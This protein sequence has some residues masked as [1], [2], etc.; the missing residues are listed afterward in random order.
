MFIMLFCIVSCKRRPPDDVTTDVLAQG[1]TD[2]AEKPE[3]KTDAEKTEDELPEKTDDDK[4]DIN[5]EKE[6]NDEKAEQNNQDN[7]QDTS[8]NSETDN[9]V[10]ETEPDTSSADSKPTT[11][12]ESWVTIT[13]EKAPPCQVTVDD[14]FE[15]G[16]VLVLLMR[17]Q[18]AARQ[19]YT[20]ADFPGVDIEEI[21][22]GEYF[23][24]SNNHIS[25]SLTLTQK[26]KGMV[27]E[28]VRILEQ[29]PIVYCATPNV[30]F[31]VIY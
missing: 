7:V 4:T 2:D 31:E 11:G 18:S 10:E 6:N 5:S 24:G 28:A 21:R 9:N 23:P 19:E 15:D 29:N 26:D 3:D 22:V 25:V 20:T 30:I 1:G 8:E 16:E 14:N 13:E 17:E 12:P 27:I